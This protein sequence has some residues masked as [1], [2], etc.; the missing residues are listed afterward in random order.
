MLCHSQVCV[1]SLLNALLQEAM[2]GK[3]KQKWSAA[4]FLSMGAKTR[5]TDHGTVQPLVMLHSAGV[6][7]K[8]VDWGQKE[9]SAQCWN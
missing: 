5:P 9:L 8:N 4:L 2:R 6:G 7:E 3:Y 1:Q